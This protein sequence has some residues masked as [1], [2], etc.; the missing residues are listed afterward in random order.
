MK[1]FNYLASFI[2]AVLVFSSCGGINKMKK[3][4][5]NVKYEVTPEVLET[6][7]GEVEFTVT[8][9][10]PEKY[11]SKKAVVEATPVLVYENGET[12]FSS[13]SMQGEKIEANNKSINYVEGG[14]F[15][16]SDKVAFNGDM[17]KSELM[18]KVKATQGNKSVDFDPIKLADGVVATSTMV[19][20][21]GKGILI[22]D[23]FQRV[24]PDSKEANIHFVINRSDVRNNELKEEDVKMFEEFINTANKAKNK[25][26][27]GFMI[28]AYASPDGEYDFNEKLSGKRKVASERYLTRSL[29][30]M[31]VDG[32]DDEG[33]YALK[34]TAEDWE[35][36]KKMLEA[37]DIGDKELILRV[38]SMYSDPA[39]REQ[40]IKNMAATYEVLKDKILPELRRSV[41]SVNI[42]VIGFSDEEISD[43]IN[44]N[45]DTLN[46]EEILYAAKLEEDAAKKV[47]IYN[48]AAE[49]VPQCF[50]AYTGAGYY[51]MT[52]MKF[53]EAEA[54]FMKAK[55]LNDNDVSKNNLAA[56]ALYKG[57][58]DK[59]EELLTSVE[60]PGKETSYGMGVV[61]IVKGKYDDAK[62]YL[63]DEPSYNLALVLLLLDDDQGAKNVLGNMDAD[64]AWHSYLKAVAGARM[65]DSEYTFNNLRASVEKDENMKDLAK[66]DLEFA[67]YFED[68]T[69]K[70]I[71]E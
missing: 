27:K 45:P 71:V 9:V 66:T 51:Q 37:S 11:F 52:L 29:K 50:R 16:H 34:S 20:E 36:F 42:D 65:D 25:E 67:K 3:E 38:L 58:I 41:L 4:A 53:D 26:F 22:G 15:T 32:V 39:V 14:K 40:E 24:I 28:D 47:E 5:A 62:N 10:F 19:Y 59:A 61:S 44:S 35:G 13:V 18:L 30:K 46:L 2:L 56:V 12:E 55:E 63:G 70:S 64:N 60:K 33:L 1:K 49:R 6:H 57:E 8:G 68:D 17:R 54:S 43:Y 48:Y 7:A 21:S 69:F 23:K 31:K